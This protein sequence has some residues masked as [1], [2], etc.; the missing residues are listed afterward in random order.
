MPSAEI[1]SFKPA[2]QDLAQLDGPIHFFSI[3]VTH[4]LR[5]WKAGFQVA[6]FSHNSR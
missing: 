2:Y 6:R 5:F 3:D 4:C 1:T